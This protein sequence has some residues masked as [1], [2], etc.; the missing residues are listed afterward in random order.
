MSEQE[1]L[2]Y[3]RSLLA[4][5]KTASVFIDTKAWVDDLEQRFPH[6]P[7]A[8]LEKLLRSEA[9]KVGLTAP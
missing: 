2:D 7:R 5:P 9:A 8:K 4:P 3:V 6:L 1:V